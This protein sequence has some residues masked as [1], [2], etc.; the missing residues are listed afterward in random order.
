MNRENLQKLATFLA[1]GELPKDVKFS[2]GTYTGYQHSDEWQQTTCGTAGCAVGF[3]PFAG[4]QKSADEGW[5]EYS[6]RLF[7][8]DYREWAW[9]FDEDWKTVDDTPLGAAKRI[10]YLLDNED[11]PS[12][13]DEYYIQD[14]DANVYTDTVVKK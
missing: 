4:F 14:D 2:M 6:G 10:Q 11:V 13:F 8:R 12:R 7:T 5:S 9:C 1:Y 3:A